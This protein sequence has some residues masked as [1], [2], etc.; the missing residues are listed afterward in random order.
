[1]T[2]PS[3]RDRFNS[4]LKEEHLDEI[5]SSFREPGFCDEVPLYSR[6][7]QVDFLKQYGE[8]D[9]LLL[10]LSLDFLERV[11]S[12]WTPGKPKRL[13]AVTIVRDDV[14]E[15]IVPYIFVCNSAPKTRL[16]E[17]HLSPPSKGLGQHIQNLLRKT[18]HP[19]DYSV[20]EDRHTVPGEVRV[21]VSYKSPPQGVMSIEAFS[22]GMSA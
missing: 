1:M 14:D 7:A 9:R 12:E 19:Q 21:F 18:A 10:E 11:K 8:V 17:L 15:H 13:I 20:L 5:P 6:Y 3:A 22:N 4:V 2:P 16:K